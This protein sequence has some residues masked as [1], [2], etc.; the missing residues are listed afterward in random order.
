MFDML[1]VCFTLSGLIGLVVASRGRAL[2]GFAVFGLSIGL[3]VLGKGPAILIHVLPVA[4]AAPLWAKPFGWAGGWGRWYAGIGAAVLGGAGIGLAWALPAAAAGG[5]VYSNAILWGQSAGRMVD[6]FAHGRPFWWFAA[7]LPAMILPWLIWPPV[8]RAVRA[9]WRRMKTDGGTRLCV[10]WFA[11]AFLGF[12]AISGKQPHYLLPEFPAL[13]LLASR[14]L[15]GAHGRGDAFWRPIDRSLP[16]VFFLLA[17]ALIAG[18]LHFDLKPSWATSIGD[19]QLWPLAGMAAAALVFARLPQGGG[20]VRRDDRRHS[21]DPAPGD[22]RIARFQAVL[23]GAQA[24]R[25]SGGGFRDLREIPRAVP[26]PRPPAPADRDCRRPGGTGRLAC[27]PSQGDDHRLAR[28]PARRGGARS[29]RPVPFAPDRRLAKQPLPAQGRPPEPALTA[30]P[31]R[32][33]PKVRWAGLRGA[34]TPRNDG[35]KQEEGN[36][37][38]G[39]PDREIEQGRGPKRGDKAE[40]GK[41]TSVP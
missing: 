37:P 2:R 34:G 39:R 29:E 33:S 31:G 18:A 15:A 28:K 7:I 1:H 16:A 10:I 8:W 36:Q 5:E 35:R 19:A 26:F 12:S 6:S 21:P 11:V 38:P 14:A 40:L 4:L 30:A 3:G 13:A 9:E 17:A 23:A 20:A 25:G 32:L 24:V 27:R 22:G 41:M